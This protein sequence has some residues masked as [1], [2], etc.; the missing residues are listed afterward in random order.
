[1]FV[2]CSPILHFEASIMSLFASILCPRA[3]LPHFLYLPLPPFYNSCPL[4]NLEEWVAVAL[5][6]PFPG[7]EVL[8]CSPS[9]SSLAQCSYSH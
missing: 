8:E 6:S 7:E 3:F 9:L 1:M 2:T 4:P 5:C